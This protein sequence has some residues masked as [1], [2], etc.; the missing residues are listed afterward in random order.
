MRAVPTAGPNPPTSKKEFAWKRVIVP[1]AKG[2]SIQ[3]VKRGG[4]GGDRITTKNEVRERDPP[5]E[6][7]GAGATL[8]G[9]YT[10]GEISDLL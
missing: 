6:R 3:G 8:T 9:D 4:R 7:C 5:R 1:I 2:D 10:W